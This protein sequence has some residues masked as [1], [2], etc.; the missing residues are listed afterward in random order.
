MAN[1]FEMKMK[2]LN[3][4]MKVKVKSALSSKKAFGLYSSLVCI[5]IGL[6]VG[7]IVLICMS[8]SDAFYEFGVMI[9]G[10]MNYTGLKALGNI[11]ANAAPLIMSGLAV[12]FAYKTGLF[13]I[14]VAGQY[15]MGAFG[16]L[17][18]VLQFGTNWFVGVLVA[19]IFGMIW[20]AIPGLLKAFCH[21]SEVIS[22]IML[23][24]IAL[25][26][27]NYSFQ[28]YLKDRCVDMQVG[29]KTY[30]VTKYNP[31]GILPSL[32]L[33]KVFGNTFTISIFI[34]LIFVAIVY[35]ILNK[36]TLGYQLK[37]SG[38]NKDATRYAG[39]KDKRNLIL[40]MMIAGALAGIGGALY[41]L[42][43]LQSISVQDSTSLPSVPWNGIVVA[44]ISL[45]N[46][47][48][49]VFASLFTSLISQGA[50]MMTQSIF[51]AEFGD[52]ITGII[53]YLSGL[54]AFI[55]V[56]LIKYGTKIKSWKKNKSKSKA[57]K[58]EI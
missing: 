19:M 13:N 17:I 43:N 31:N 41:Y 29:Y 36:T 57:V 24:W 18:C 54:V 51:P 25:F 42:S 10:G 8:P 58:E 23:N 1:G 46:P 47:I 34:A 52:L 9:S 26:F 4:K 56:I 21:V 15:V 20:G 33:N 3:Q 49:C 53:V 38:L 16:A 35:I 37:A 28:T 48:G 5:L 30:S 44:F 45:L 22:G 50:K 6:L 55:R 2:S 40:T 11:I 39:M 14:G 32:G 7:L 12:L 27:M